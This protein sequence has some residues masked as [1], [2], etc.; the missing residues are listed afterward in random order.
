[1]HTLCLQVRFHKK[2]NKE[3]NGT[4][5]D[6]GEE[7]ERKKKSNAVTGKTAT[8]DHANSICGKPIN[9]AENGEE[10]AEA[11]TCNAVSREDM[12]CVTTRPKKWQ[13]TAPNP[14]SKHVLT[15]HLIIVLYYD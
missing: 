2:I 8:C 7:G 3:D 15:Y 14:N 1:M 13:E 5:C 9:T 4:P 12:K 11:A 10:E 6:D